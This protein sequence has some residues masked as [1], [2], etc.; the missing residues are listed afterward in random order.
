MDKKNQNKKL[1][2]TDVKKTNSFVFKKSEFFN[3]NRF[4]Y[5]KRVEFHGSRH[6][7]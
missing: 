6:R 1:P 4:D 5:I 7:G 3:K 2:L